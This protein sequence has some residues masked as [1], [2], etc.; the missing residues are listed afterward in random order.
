MR[1]ASLSLSTAVVAL[2]TL[3]TA[4]GPK[5]AAPPP[6]ETTWLRGLPGYPAVCL[7][8]VEEA[9]RLGG[10][11]AAFQNAVAAIQ[12]GDLP[13][14]RAALDSATDGHPAIEGLR[15]V[16]LLIEG[17][18]RE[19]R[20][21][22]RDLASAW[23]EDG[24]LQ[25]TAAVIYLSA[26]KGRMARGFVRSARTLLPEETETQYLYGLIERASG[27]EEAAARA[28]RSVV[29]TTPGH[30]GASIALASYHL[31]R[32]DGLLAVPLLRDARSG[33]MEVGDSLARALF[34]AGETG[35]YVAEAATL[36]WP[37]GGAKVEDAEA[38]LEALADHLGVSEDDTLRVT[39][40]TT[41]G[42]IPCTLHW[43]AAPVTVAN[44]VGLA[45]GTQPWTDPATG[46]ETTRPMYPGTRF[47]RII[48]GFMAQAG[49]PLGN[50]SGGP[51]YAFPD[52]IDP[53]LRFD[54]P[55][56]LAMA[57]AGP[58]TN[59]SQ[60]FV[61]DDLAPH[62][63]GRHTIFGTCTDTA[64]D[65]VVNMGRVPRN[66]QDA[67]LQPILIESIEF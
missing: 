64:V 48:P 28:F 45:R 60:F 35:A 31:D 59:G 20:P 34:R 66:A 9:G 47:H 42:D 49:D 67:P 41:H 53:E 7:S 26:G 29:Q 24:C 15:S 18:P 8:V 52:E 22:V 54:R 10:D 3:V 36:G 33:G 27:D 61:T 5:G 46:T 63:D 4:C 43:Q 14:A 58:D 6:A 1:I 2:T 12:E 17:E 51:G 25:H 62:L 44:F 65:T 19:A 50:G 38:P 32:G 55:G 37:L 39:L 13:A 56:R 11:R 21:I 30:P 16:V 23:P 40:H 57:N